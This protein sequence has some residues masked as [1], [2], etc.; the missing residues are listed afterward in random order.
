MSRHA[1]ESTDPELFFPPT[2]AATFRTQ[3]D[4]AKALCRR[5][6]QQ[7]RCLRTAV[8]NAEEF[9]IWGGTTPAERLSLIGSTRVRSGAWSAG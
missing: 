2:Y 4:A 1:C 7:L 9:G 5:C 6:P 8:D 3:I